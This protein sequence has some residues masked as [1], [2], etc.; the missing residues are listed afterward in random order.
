MTQDATFGSWNIAES[1]IAVEYSLVVIEEIRHAVTEGYQKFSRGGI[2]VGGVLY[3]TRENNTVRIMAMRDIVCE[4][5]HG[6]SF[7]LSD[8]DRK[9]LK[10]QLEREVGRLPG[11]QVVGWFLSHTRSEINLSESDQE[12]YKDF[13]GQPWQV[14]MVVQPGRAGA[15]RAGFF[16]READG[17]V[18][19]EHSY[20]DFNFPDRV[21]GAPDTGAAKERIARPRRDG[22][23]E[24]AAP[25]GI[26][27]APSAPAVEAPSFG[28]YGA[29]SAPPEPDA[30]PKRSPLRGWMIAAAVVL[31]AAIAAI[32]A[33]RYLGP[34]LNPE[35]LSLSVIERE[36]QLQIQWNHNSRTIT[37]AAGGDLQIVDGGSPVMLPL[38]PQDLAKGSFTYVRRTG[39]VQIRLE[40]ETSGGSKLM[41]ASRFL[42]AAPETVD[43]NEADAT[44][45][46]RDALQDE[47]TRLRTQNAA[48]ATQ[49]Q[50]LQ[51]TMTILR[52]RLGIDQS[53]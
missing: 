49:I 44:K 6:P 37:G 35:P 50:Q 26:A 3:G 23:L 5:A 39:D 28:G 18:K 36:G 46:E 1:P 11:L 51:R 13:F 31:V 19:A 25:E 10:L 22:S 53:K 48:Q 20:L 30:A 52:A 40:V 24:S 45:L 47:V 43:P 41:E 29:R 15:M 33:L 9:E 42:G 21:A 27:S 2:E 17:S 4:H 12:L 34:R 7:V 16:V 8:N 32:A 14:A 38:N